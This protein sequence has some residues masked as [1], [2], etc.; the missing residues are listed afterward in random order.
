ML[1]NKKISPDS[2]FTQ[3]GIIKQGKKS[4][5]SNWKCMFIR[6]LREIG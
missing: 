2:H 4:I 3:E 1:L 6:F 5:F